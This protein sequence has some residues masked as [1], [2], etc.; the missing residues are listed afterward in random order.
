[1]SRHPSGTVC[2]VRD[3]TDAH[4][5]RPAVILTHDTHPFGATDCTIIQTQGE[6]LRLQ[7][8]DESDTTLR[9][10]PSIAKPDILTPSI[11]VLLQEMR[12]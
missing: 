1:M 5:D 8:Q 11:P 9:S 7:P 10:P 6:Y 3:P 12:L 2:W 4:A